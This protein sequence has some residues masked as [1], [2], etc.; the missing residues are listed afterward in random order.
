MREPVV[1]EPIP[2]LASLRDTVLRLNEKRCPRWRFRLAPDVVLQLQPRP[3][4]HLFE[5]I[6][7]QGP[8]ITKDHFT[9]RANWYGSGLTVID[10]DIDDG[11]K[12][13]YYLDAAHL[14]PRNEPAP[15]QW[16]VWLGK[17]YHT[18]Q[19]AL[20][21]KE[22]TIAA[23]PRLQELDDALM[24]LPACLLCGKVLTD[25]VSR[26][27]LIGPECAHNHTLDVGRLF[28]LS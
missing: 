26:A 15:G 8:G 11:E 23:L 9:H 6:V 21:L 13:R 17:W 22:S 24:F 14:T 25:P 10:V 1:I 5:G 4:H 18:S 20:D 28:K 2:T 19:T 27:R 16:T 7:I 3:D 12:I